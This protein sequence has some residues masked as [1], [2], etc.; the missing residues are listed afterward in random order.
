MSEKNTEL[1]ELE[2]QLADLQNQ[3]A[4]RESRRAVED[5]K[6]KIAQEVLDAKAEAIA[7]K[8]EADG[9]GERGVDFEVFTA[10]DAIFAFR[11]PPAIAWEKFQSFT[12]LLFAKDEPVPGI[13]YKNLAKASLLRP[14]GEAYTELGTKEAFDAVCAK[15][16]SVPSNAY[17]VLGRMADGQG[18]RRA[19]K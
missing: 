10:K 9:H 17:L 19:G 7:D 2:K 4:E 6:R 1:S 5:L 8:L 18:K 11:R 14:E 3:R 12:Q 16:V 13:E 15:Y